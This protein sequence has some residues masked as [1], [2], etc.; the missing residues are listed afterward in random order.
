M[1]CFLNQLTGLSILFYALFA[2]ATF[3]FDHNCFIEKSCL[4]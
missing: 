3:A 1:I 2:Y 4:A